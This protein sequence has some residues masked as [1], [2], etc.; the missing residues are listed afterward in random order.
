LGRYKTQKG[1]PFPY[2]ARSR[3]DEED[4]VIFRQMSLACPAFLGMVEGAEYMQMDIM[5][6]KL[7]TRKE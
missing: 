7:L 1:E 5:N 4:N 6:H 3:S 2:P